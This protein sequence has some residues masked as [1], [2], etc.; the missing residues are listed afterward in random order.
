MSLDI[1]HFI[2]LLPMD[3]IMSFNY[4]YK[5]ALLLTSLIKVRILSFILCLTVQIDT[6]NFVFAQD[7]DNNVNNVL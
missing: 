4:Y 3:G 5:V 1:L 2:L 6:P 7:V